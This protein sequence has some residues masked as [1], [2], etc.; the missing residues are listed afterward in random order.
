MELTEY[1]KSLLKEVADEVRHKRFKMYKDG[2][3]L[4]KKLIE[5]D[6]STYK[7]IMRIIENF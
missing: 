3:E 1:E 5:R 4:R 2:G 6:L 7:L